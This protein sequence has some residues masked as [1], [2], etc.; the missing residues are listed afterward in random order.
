MTAI[1]E[2]PPQPA[3]LPP[4]SERAGAST[5]PAGLFSLTRLVQTHQVG[6]WRYVCFLGAERTEA[7]DI[8]QETFLAIARAAFV[9]RDERQTAGYLR[10]VA[11]NQLLALRRRQRREISTVELEAADSVW[12]AAAGPD[13]NLTGYLDALR[14][15]LAGLEGRSR[16][17]ID[18]HYRDGADREAIATALDM[19]PD[20]VKTLLRR[21]RQLLRECI[22]RKLNSETTS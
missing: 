17:A 22:E 20:G 16:Q 7:D 12:A 3:A 11:R 15:C 13:G 21:T 14:D 9:E 10:V 18:L 1:Q 8:T 19:K 2:Q 4:E 5:P 6:V